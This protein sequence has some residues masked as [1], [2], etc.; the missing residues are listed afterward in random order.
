[1]LLSP[2]RADVSPNAVKEAVVMGLPVIGTAIGGIPDYVF[3]GQNGLL[4]PAGDLDAL[5]KALEEAARHP[6][7]SRGEVDPAT[8]ARCRD[9][10]SPARMAEGFLRV[11]GKVL[12]ASSGSRQ[13]H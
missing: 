3:P 2:S 5:V 1:M 11:Y 13:R 10:L 12:N 7:F 8:L 6:Q 4:V 9:Y